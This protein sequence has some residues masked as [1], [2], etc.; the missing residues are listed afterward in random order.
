MFE[1]IVELEDAFDRALPRPRLTGT[2][3]EGLIAAARRWSEAVWDAANAVTRRPMSGEEIERGVA[4]SRRPVFICGVHRSGTTLVRDLLDGHPALCVL[5]AEGTFYTNHRRHL[6]RI[7]PIEAPR[8]MGCEWLRRLANPANQPPY[9][10]IGRSTTSASPSVAFARALRAWW[11]VFEAR[12]SP[13]VSGWPL[14]AVALAYASHSSGALDAAD[15]PQWVEKTP[16]NERFLAELWKDFPDARIVHVV[17]DPVA[18]VASRKRMEERATGGFGRMRDVLGDLAESY[19]IAAE[20]SA[21]GDVRRYALVRFEDLLA[22]PGRTVDRLARFLD[23]KTLPI[24]RQPTVAGLPASA[25]SSFDAGDAAGTIV[26]A[27][28]RAD[29]ARLSSEERLRVAVMVGDAAA[30]LGYAVPA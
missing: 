12:L 4:L 5:P 21:R 3:P 14:A 22:H 16:T 8:F 24:L 28:A 18:V 2:P 7:G 29:G 23:V 25:N 17:R 9:W 1:P 20:Q 10:C 13:T 6:A 11:S 27:R 19:R 15:T 30:A 26:S